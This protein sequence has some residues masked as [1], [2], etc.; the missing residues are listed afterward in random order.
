MATAELRANAAYTS[1]DTRHPALHHNV[2]LA[3]AGR[4]FSTLRELTDLKAFSHSLRAQSHPRAM[5]PRL[6][7]VENQQGK[8]AYP[9]N[10]IW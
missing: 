3:H 8:F 10:H 5:R 4:R 9:R 6:V 7:Q 1:V 2:R